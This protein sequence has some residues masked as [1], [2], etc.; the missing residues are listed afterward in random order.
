MPTV[1]G[2]PHAE[3][4]MGLCRRHSLRNGPRFKE[5][6]ITHDSLSPNS[7]LVLGLTSPQPSRGPQGC[8]GPREPALRL[9]AHHH[10]VL[11]EVVHLQ[12]SPS[13]RPNPGRNLFRLLYIVIR[14]GCAASHR[15]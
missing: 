9:A 7:H 11:L 1:A 4:D 8:R 14:A 10:A 15:Y 13:P 6:R 12:A 3:A 2:R 5:L